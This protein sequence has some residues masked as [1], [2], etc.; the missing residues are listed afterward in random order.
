MKSIKADKNKQMY[1]KE[2]E[3]T[4]PCRKENWKTQNKMIANGQK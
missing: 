4:N 1:Q 3:G 2:N